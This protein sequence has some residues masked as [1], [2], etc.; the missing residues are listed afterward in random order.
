M[1]KR[2]ELAFTQAALAVLALLLMSKV[3]SRE[4]KLAKDSNTPASPNVR[5]PPTPE[6][7]KERWGGADASRMRLPPGSVLLLLV[8][9][10]SMYT[11]PHAESERMLGWGG[12]RVEVGSRT[13][14]LGA[15][16]AALLGP[17]MATEPEAE[18][19]VPREMSRSYPMIAPLARSELFFGH[20]G[21]GDGIHVLNWFCQI[22]IHHCYERMQVPTLNGAN[23]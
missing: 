15:A 14:L 7:L 18:S 10:P 1:Y 4:G 16:G 6:P 20:G 22:G 21:D 13:E 12:W 19:C 23:K 5:R 2:Q 8:R 3:S 9:G 17:S 11:E